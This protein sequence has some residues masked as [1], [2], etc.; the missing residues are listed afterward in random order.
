MIMAPA[1]I[2]SEVKL[3]AIRVGGS[4]RIGTFVRAYDYLTR[5]V[6]ALDAT[7][8]GPTGLASYYTTR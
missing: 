2:G 4:S 1:P 6:T 3:A 7:E 5:R 8:K